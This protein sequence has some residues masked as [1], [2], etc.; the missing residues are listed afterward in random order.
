LLPTSL[1]GLTLHTID[2]LEEREG[3]S[4]FATGGMGRTFNRMGNHF[5]GRADKNTASYQ[6]SMFGR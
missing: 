3:D 1:S 4:M 2:V 6:Q 5:V